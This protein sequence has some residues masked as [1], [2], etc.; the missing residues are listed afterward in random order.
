MDILEIDAASNR[1]IDEMRDLKEKIRLQP[2]NARKKVYI[3]DEVHMLTTEAFNALLKTLEE[4]PTHAMF[5]L[6]TTEPHKVPATI[7][8]RCFH[9]SFL[10][11]TSEELV[12][13]FG[14]IVTGENLVADQETL[15]AI[16]E[17][18]EGGFR[19]G[20]KMLEEIVSIV[21][22][23]D[24]KRTLTKN[25][26]EERY[27]TGSMSQAVRDLLTCLESRDTKRAIL[28]ISHV[29]AQGIPVRDYLQAVLE[30]LHQVLLAKLGV[31]DTPD[32]LPQTDL[33]RVQEIIATLSLA[34]GQLRSAVIQQLPL[35]LAIITLT[36]NT[37]PTTVFSEVIAEPG[38]K[39]VSLSNESEGITTASL[40]RQ[41]GNIVK[42]KALYGTPPAE[43]V[44]ETIRPKVN[45]ISLMSYDIEKG[46]TKEWLDEFW[47]CLI[48]QMK[49]HNHTIAGALQISTH[50]RRTPA[51]V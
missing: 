22:V 7:L 23:K 40:R 50:P 8:S 48:E 5:I 17:L 15:L 32:L 16:A 6:C 37:A 46:P 31:G 3:I 11:A 12:R 20:T 51:I 24:G 25:L 35:E 41:V 28:L 36:G 1:G 33:P 30:K 14:R 29:L 4:P 38:V 39:I 44:D 18:A 42:I 47:R 45:K 10:P 13:S 43:A 34:Y 2:I 27:H 9:T 19:D 49:T 26:V 21:E